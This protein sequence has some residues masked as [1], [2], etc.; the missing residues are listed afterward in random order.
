MKI[1]VSCLMQ[2]TFVVSAC[3][4]RPLL[5]NIKNMGKDVC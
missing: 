5:T 1:C 4:V 3:H 2:I